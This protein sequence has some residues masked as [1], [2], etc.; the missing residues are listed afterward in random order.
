[1]KTA[2]ALCGGGS[3]GAYEIGVW[4][5]LRE[6][7]F[8]FDIITGSSIGAINGAMIAQDQYDVAIDMWKKISVGDV[9]ANGIDFDRNFL[10]NVDF[11]KDSH[12]RKFV[13]GFF[14]NKGADTTPLQN[15]LEEKIAP[16]RV[17]HSNKTLGIVICRFPSFSEVDIVVNDLKDDE[18]VPYIM[19]SASCW[20]VFPVYNYKG[21]DYVDGGWRNNLPIDFALK[22]GADQVVAVLLNSLPHAQ[23]RDLFE[24][25][26]VVFPKAVFSPSPITRLK[27]TLRWAIWMPRKHSEA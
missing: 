23:R 3:L 8:H 26:T 16:L 24:L 17:N 4:Q 21:Q 10:K 22:L 5:Y 19:A 15:M 7:S 11:S 14:K 27:A 9:M 25:P 6:H 13:T 20:P 18:V 1:M 12:W 2:L